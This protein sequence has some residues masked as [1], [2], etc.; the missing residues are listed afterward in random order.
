MEI[1]LSLLAFI[2]GA[3]FV[4][5]NSIW[6]WGGFASRP[7]PRWVFNRYGRGGLVNA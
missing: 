4:L 6:F 7:K 3:A 2:I 5:L 1:F